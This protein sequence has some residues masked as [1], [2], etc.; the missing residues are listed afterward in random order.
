MSLDPHLHHRR[1]VRLR[2]RDYSSPGH[3]FVTLCTHA[4]QNLFGDVVDGHMRLNRAGVEVERFWNDIP[5]HF[6][7]AALDEYV[8]MPNHVHGII[9]IIDHV[10]WV[11][12]PTVHAVGVPIVPELVVPDDQHARGN[13]GPYMWDVGANNYLPLRNPNRTVSYPRDTKWNPRGTSR[14]IGSMVRGF[15]IGVTGWYRSQSWI[16]PV[17][18]RNYHDHIV[19][20]ERS[21]DRIRAYIRANPVNWGRDRQNP[22]RPSSS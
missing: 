22:D 11:S 8:V 7:H 10:G 5:R 9:R 21:L 3:Y 20:H 17:W 18:Q 15:K 16:G 14:T 12:L 13:M 4:R 2:A 19:R 1:S 6:P